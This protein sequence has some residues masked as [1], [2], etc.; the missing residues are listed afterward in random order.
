MLSDIE[1]TSGLDFISYAFY[2]YFEPIVTLYNLITP[3]NWYVETRHPFLDNDLVDFFALRIP[4]NLIIEKRFL[5]KAM[6]Y[7]FPVLSDIP[8][9]QG[10][11]PN[12]PQ[13]IALLGKAKRSIKNRIKRNLERLSNG[14]LTFPLDYRG[15]DY[16]L[17]TGSRNY[18]LN[19][20]LDSKT[21]NR[22]YFRKEYIKK[23]IKE[24]M[25]GEKNHDQLI[26]D[27][28]NFELMNRM[29]L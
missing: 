25:K 21:L 5:Q 4:P 12:S 16:Y 6:N 15:Y 22:G 3:I 7:F 19:L 9:E 11:T 13:P 27:I 2:H 10:Y 1:F 29:F 24:H 20:L 17:R 28:I 26:C 18:A 14:R 23:I 8:L